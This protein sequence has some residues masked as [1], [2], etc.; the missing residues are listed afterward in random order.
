MVHFSENRYA[1]FN[2]S[3]EK[4]ILMA[5][6]SLCASPLQASGTQLRCFN[7]ETGTSVY[8][9]TSVT[10]PSYISQDVSFVL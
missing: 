6:S 4:S 3:K 9:V 2:A 8:T 1:I 7:L 10:L 5:Y